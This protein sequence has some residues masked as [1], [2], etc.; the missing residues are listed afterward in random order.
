M[1]SDRQAATDH[2]DEAR[3][4]PVT[5]AT[6]LAPFPAADFLERVWL[7]EFLCVRGV[8]GKYA[9]LLPWDVLNRIVEQHRPDFTRIHL[10]KNG[11][12]PMS[13]FVRE[14]RYADGTAVPQILLTELYAQLREGATLLLNGVDEVYEPTRQLAENLE[15]VLGS[16]VGMAAY[17]GFRATRSV[18]TH[19]DPV[20]VIILQVAGRK[21]WTLYGV[22]TPHPL[23]RTGEGQGTKPTE[24]VWDGVLEDGDMLYLPRGWWHVAVPM[25]GPSLSIS[26]TVTGRTG[27]DLVAWLA[28]ELRSSPL[29]RQEIPRLVSPADRQAHADRLRAVMLD[30]WGPDLVDRYLAR[31]DATV[32]PRPRVGLPWVAL[33]DTLPPSDDTVV[34]LFTPWPAVIRPTADGAVELA[35]NERQWRFANA[36]EP[37]LRR[38]VSGEAVSVA[39][40]CTHVD[41]Q[42]DRETVR[43]FLSS[44]IVDGLVAIEPSG[45]Q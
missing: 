23:M 45:E 42:L 3:S 39:E 1:M 38:L 24:P 36:A 20:D 17:A 4:A 25:D 34:R 33:P 40:L 14:T 28:E 32:R 16:R 37:L 22:T 31:C 27:V 6:M 35:V 43:A 9:E 30:A 7:R 5:L 18:D 26:I 8:P 21:H 12:L 10:Y 2:A 15:R 44:L 19:W 11:R 13:A 41:G 29:F